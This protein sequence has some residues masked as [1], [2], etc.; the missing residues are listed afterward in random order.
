M[1]PHFL[2]NS[3]NAVASLIGEDPERAEAALEKLSDILRY[4]LDA[5]RQPFVPLEQELEAVAGYL[6]LETLRFPDRLTAALHVEPGIGAVPVPPLFLQPLVE[7]AVRHGIAPRREGGRLEVEIQRCED[8]L[9]VRVED[10]GPG[11]G[12]SPHRGA[13]VAL[14]DLRKR[15]ALLY[16]DR[17]SLGVDRGALGGCRV[18]LRL[19]LRGVEV[20]EREDDA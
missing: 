3:L 15:L 1:Q 6:E 18:T 12:G 7:N 2:F 11:I 14:A 10:D 13:G 8:E 9:R 19:P 20:S 4:A 16:G 5:S 17:A